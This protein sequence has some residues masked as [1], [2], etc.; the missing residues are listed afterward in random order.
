MFYNR[1]LVY[2][3]VF[4]LAVEIFLFCFHTKSRCLGNIGNRISVDGSI[5]FDTNGKCNTSLASV[6][7]G[8][9]NDISQCIAILI[10]GLL[11]IQRAFILDSLS[12]NNLSGQLEQG[13]PD[14]VE[15]LPGIMPRVIT[16]ISTRT[17]VPVIAGGLLRDKADVMAAMR[18]G[19]S[20]VSTSA[21]ELWDI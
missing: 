20:A 14:F 21:P 18:A 3:F 1:K 19:A 4:K 8:N 10:Y 2:R 9:G 6:F 16:E 12:L 13:K 11:T 7:R 5:I 17:R 15:I